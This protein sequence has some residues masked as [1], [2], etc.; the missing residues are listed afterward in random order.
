MT[1][2]AHQHFWRYSAAEYGW[3]SES[4]RR[5]RRDF[6]PPDLRREAA[7]AGVAGA[8]A[9]QARQTA[10]ETR[11]LLDLAR[12]RRWILG[13][14]GWVPLVSPGV[15]GILGELAEEGK[16]KG[17][18]HVLQDEADDRYMLRPDFNAGVRAVTAAGLTYD[19]LVYARQLP[20]AVEFV[21][22]H[23]RQL[24]VLDHM[25]KPDIRSGSYAAWSGWVRELARRENVYCKVSGLVTEADWTGWTEAQLRPYLDTVVEAFGPRRLMFGSD[26]PLCLLAVEYRRWHGF[27]ASYAAELGPGERDRILGGT[28]IEAY[29]LACAPP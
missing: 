9:V 6:L 8:V 21:D 17:C 4:M 14:V 23:P 28:A 26:W 20:Q 29:S 19:I 24:F 1:V 25:G 18:R 2:D 15:D 11:F 7:A 22:R 12:G 27:V 16:F 5:L 13:V 3:I 10:A